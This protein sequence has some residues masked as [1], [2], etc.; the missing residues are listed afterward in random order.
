[1]PP[2]ARDRLA[3]RRRVVCSRILAEEA[4]EEPIGTARARK[5]REQQRAARRPAAA[6]QSGVRRRLRGRWFNLVPVHQYQLSA[7][8]TS[9][10]LIVAGLTAL[11]YLAAVWTPLAMRPLIGR[12]FRIDMPGG[13]ADWAGAQMLV[14]AAG[15]SFLVYQLR[16][17]RG[18]D[19]HGRY[20]MWRPIIG[21]L[22]LLSIDAVT[23]LRE[24]LAVLI[25]VTWAQQ[26]VMDGSDV[27]RLMLLLVGIGIT[28][29]LF[30][31]M[32][33]CPLAIG[34]LICATISLGVPT[35][36]RLNMIPSTA[37]LVLT[38]AGAARLAGRA[39]VLSAAIC[40]L[41]RLFR[42]VQGID[43]ANA[44]LLSQFRLPRLVG[45]T[46][47]EATDAKSRSRKQQ[48]ID[49]ESIPVGF[50]ARWFPSRENMEDEAIDRRKSKAK[51]STM[52]KE[53][54][55][56]EG[57]SDQ[58]DPSDEHDDERV[59][60]NRSAQRPQP[61]NATATKS[62][63]PVADSSAE[64][65][66]N[67]P[68]NQQPTAKPAVDPKGESTTHLAPA[69]KSGLGGWLRGKQNDSEEKAEGGAAPSVANPPSTNE[70]EAPR[71]GWFARKKAEPVS[72][73]SSSAKEEPVESEAAP[74]EKRGWFSRKKKTSGPGSESDSDSKS[75][76]TVKPG[77]AR[78]PQ[79]STPQSSAANSTEDDDDDED[80]G[81]VDTSGMSRSEKKRLKKQM[82]RQGR[83]A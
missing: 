6:Y 41:R 53:N 7:V 5:Q 40:Y 66:S 29:P 15:C 3:N 48:T 2:A 45:A 33:R 59:V 57:T 76:S 21:L 16:R 23:H 30:A 77:A 44:G 61:T 47:D 18:D 82:R 71:K 31:E 43:D 1:M 73:S 8:L 63:Q 34:L 49:A 38:W 51:Q 14:L 64:Q 74:A 19:Y 46:T 35:A 25:D 4:G 37:E 50:W 55:F 68:T 26:S 69:R 70:P 12:P 36:L 65:R 83:A 42:E 58:Q 10:Y 56:S 13:I 39:C 28:M 17:Y 54:E 27:V 22:L 79:L 78:S 81:D 75:A 62:N 72:A 11:G 24:A 32:Q 9:I 80:Y 52:A 20:R 67:K 60:P